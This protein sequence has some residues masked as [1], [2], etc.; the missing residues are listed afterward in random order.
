MKYHIKTF[1]CAM[2]SSDSERVASILERIGYENR[3][4]GCLKGDVACVDPCS[5]AD[6]E[7]DSGIRY[8]FIED[9]CIL[10]KAVM[11]DSD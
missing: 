5:A 11:R 8:P 2:N 10:C 1:G 3:I 9:C 7:A 4:G 6:V